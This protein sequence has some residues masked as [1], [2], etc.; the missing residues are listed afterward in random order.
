MQAPVLWHITAISWQFIKY[1]MTARSFISATRVG[2]AH[3][4][5][6]CMCV[7]TSDYSLNTHHHHH[8]SCAPRSRTVFKDYDDAYTTHTQLFFVWGDGR[9]TMMMF[10]L[11]CRPKMMDASKRVGETPQACA[12][13]QLEW[14]SVLACSTHTHRECARV[15]MMLASVGGDFGRT[16]I[17]RTHS[18]LKAARFSI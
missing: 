17:R 3:L 4:C 12:V 7:C 16:L 18:A 14:R 8:T 5:L 15:K 2:P 6:C 9:R 1:L 11:H 13:Q 10:A